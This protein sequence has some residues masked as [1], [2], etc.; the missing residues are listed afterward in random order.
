MNF[1][2]EHDSYYKD[3]TL[4]IGM[5]PEHFFKDVFKHPNALKMLNA[6]LKNYF[7]LVFI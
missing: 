1:S 7:T 3:V 2:T 5:Y 6:L 4:H